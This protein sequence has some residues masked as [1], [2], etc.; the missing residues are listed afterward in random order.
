[1]PLLQ[2]T[3]NT[4][5]K[6]KLAPSNEL[7]SAEMLPLPIGRKIDPQSVQL[8]AGHYCFDLYLYTGHANDVPIDEAG[9]LLT[10]RVASVLKLLPI[11]SVKLSQAELIKLPQGHQL[12]AED[13]SIERGHY[14]IRC[15]VFSGHAMLSNAEPATKAER[16]EAIKLECAKQGVIYAE[17]VAYVLATAEHETNKTFA[18][19]VEAYWVKPESRRLAV[20]QRMY[21]KFGDSIMPNWWGRGLVQLTHRF[22]YERY[23]AILG[24]DLVNNPDK[25]LEFGISAFILVHGMKHGIFTGRKLSDYM[26]GGKG[27]RSPRGQYDYI[28]ARRIV[29]GK[30]RAYDIAQLARRWELELR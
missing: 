7:S 20:L 8:K 16:I 17:Q 23:S 6:L 1:M 30:D 14:K 9:A 12:E 15:Y 4:P 29:N 26:P 19:I 27:H 3:A 21:R 10:L 11:Q 2:I 22:N 25:V 5:L 24:H 28:N 13:V 18:P